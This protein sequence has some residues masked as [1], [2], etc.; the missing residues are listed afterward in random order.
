MRVMITKNAKN[1]Y[2][3]GFFARWEGGMA[4]FSPSNGRPLAAAAQIFGFF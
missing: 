3:V 1:A 2:T 4:N